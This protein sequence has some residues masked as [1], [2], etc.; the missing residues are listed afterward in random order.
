MRLL[1]LSFLIA[2]T[3]SVAACSIYRG[4][5]QQDLDAWV[6]VPVEALDTHSLLPFTIPMYRTLTTSGIEI[7]NYANG[8]DVGDCLGSACQQGWQ[9][10]RLKYLHHVL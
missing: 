1:R 8:Y 6:G 2:V 9:L 7:R 4:V 3:V 10:H 5:R